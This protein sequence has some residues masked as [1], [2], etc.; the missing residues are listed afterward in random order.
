MSEH[1]EY[2]FETP[3]PVRLTVELGSGGLHLHAV[4]TATTRVR[5]R[6]RDADQVRVEQH[7]RRIEIIAPRQRTGFLAGKPD[8]QVD[9]RVPL[10][11]ALAA[12]TG[13]ADVRAEGRLDGCQVK[14]GSG[15]VRL[16]TLGGPSLV[17]TGSGD[18]RIA[19]AHAELKVQSGSGEVTLGHTG[20]AVVVSTGSGD[21]GIDST[22]APATVKTGSGDLA[23]G[24]ARRG[25][26]TVKSASGG[27]RVGIPAGIPLWTDISTVSGQIRSTRGGA[28]EPAEGQEYVELRATT[29]SGDVVLVEA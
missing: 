2:A 7:G 16:E 3:D 17:E 27:V 18:V 28:G 24:S 5:V 6:G 8:L 23:I 11:S 14:S 21:V 29:V 20:A 12:R 25:R 1:T 9:A 13:S 4:E 19:A 22:E 15:D 26:I 10:D